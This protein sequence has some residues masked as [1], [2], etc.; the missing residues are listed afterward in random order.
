MLEV[1]HSLIFVCRARRP[2]HNLK[3]NSGNLHTPPLQS[4]SIVSSAT[5][6]TPLTPLGYFRTSIF[7]ILPYL[8]E[9]H[10][11]GVRRAVGACL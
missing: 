11:V 10:T 5:A 3:R 6:C 2:P 7:H 1:R 8:E 4:V 9:E